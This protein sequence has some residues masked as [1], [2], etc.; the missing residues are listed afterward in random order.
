MTQYN[1]LY[2]KFSQSQLNKLK[3]GTKYGAGV[4]L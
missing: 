3:S 4:F 1:I 2:A